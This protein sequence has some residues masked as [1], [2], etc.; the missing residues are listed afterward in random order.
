MSLR[1][2]IHLVDDDAMFRTALANVI[3]LAGHT[4]LL[5]ES[6]GD[7]LIGYARSVTPE[8]AIFDLQMPGPNG[9]ELHASLAAKGIG[10]P[11][12][13]LSAFG[14]VPTTV[15]AMRGGAIDFLTK[16]V[17]RDTLLTALDAALR[18]DL[19]QS[20]RYERQTAIRS[21]VRQLSARE[22]AVFEQVLA[23]KRNKQIAGELGIA[24]RTVKTHRAQ[25]MEKMQV[26]S[27]AELPSSRTNSMVKRPQPRAC[28]CR[29]SYA[30]LRHAGRLENAPI[31]TKVPM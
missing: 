25:L 23:G 30:V 4:V 29:V 27:V 13:F 20:V 6:A 16:P 31:G 14:D 22:F 24:E 18:H 10:V 26:Q 17:A 2:V 9:L 15:R 11:V 1:G 28:R 3:E 7:F 5:Y 12:V 19:A 21:R 8:C